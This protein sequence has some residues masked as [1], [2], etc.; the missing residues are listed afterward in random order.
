MPKKVVYFLKKRMKGIFVYVL[1]FMLALERAL[2]SKSEGKAFC[3]IFVFPL[4]RTFV[5]FVTKVSQ[6]VYI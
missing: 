2:S 4:V 3:M 6:V 5:E 1:E